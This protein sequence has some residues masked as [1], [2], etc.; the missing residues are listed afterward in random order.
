MECLEGDHIKFDFLGKDS[1]RYENEVKAHPKVWRL[2]EKFCRKDGG[3]KGELEEER[4]GVIAGLVQLIKGPI[5]QQRGFEICFTVSAPQTCLR[6]KRAY[7][8]HQSSPSVPY[9]VV[10]VRGGIL[11]PSTA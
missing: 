8:E 5:L 3:N 4:G 2:V 7:V 11:L 1:I 9:G 6:N 10:L